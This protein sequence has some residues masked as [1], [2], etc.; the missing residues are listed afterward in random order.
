MHNPGDGEF[1]VTNGFGFG[2][3][4]GGKWNMTGIQLSEDLDWI[5]GNHQ[6][7]YG[8]IFVL[9][10]ENQYN[11]Q[12]SNGSVNFG[13]ARAGMGYADFYLGLP[14]TITQAHGQQDFERGKQWGLYFTDNWRVNNR[15][16]VNTGVRWEPYRPW[17]HEY[18]WVNH[19]EMANFLS[20]KKS[21]VYLDA[22]AGMM[23]PGDPGFP[24][25][26]MHS[27]NMML[28]APRVGLVFDPRGSGKEVIRAGYGLFYDYPPASYNI[29]VSNSLPYG[30]SGH[31]EQ[32]G[33]TGPVDQST[34]RQSRSRFRWP[35][36]T[37]SSHS[38]ARITASRWIFRTAI[39]SSGI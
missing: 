30:R 36:R 20:G 5:H 38:R 10:I 33:V 31:A 29:R 23:F 28:F 12:F 2:G 1:S 39:R 24:D 26:G 9:A 14:N 21:Q 37:L 25:K 13:T 8:G 3:S 22:P 32:S 6:I 27:G 35:T 4:G 7:G 11:N 16:S 34:G 17:Q 19:F 18:G 15:F